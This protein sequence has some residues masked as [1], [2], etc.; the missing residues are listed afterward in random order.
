MRTLLG[1]AACAAVAT[2]TFGADVPVGGASLRLS[3]SARNPARRGAAARLDD[4]AIAAPFGDP[5][6]DGATLVVHGGAATG[7][8][9]VR[10]DLPAAHWSPMGRD[11][12]RRG[13]RYRD[14]G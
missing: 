5:R 3:A 10:V 6:A 7:Q 2:T 11:G 14:R 1:L 4:R 9:Y 13:W 8:C 12:S